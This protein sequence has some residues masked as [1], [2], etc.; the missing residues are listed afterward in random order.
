[1]LTTLELTSIADNTLY[2]DDFGTL[3]NGAGDH[4]FAGR[5]A[6]QGGAAL[7]RGVVKFDV[8][9]IPSGATINSVRL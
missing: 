2:E 7:R 1:M 4:L 3:S 9:S 8:S 5:V 6:G